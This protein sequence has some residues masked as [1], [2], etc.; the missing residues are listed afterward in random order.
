[1]SARFANRHL[2]TSHVIGDCKNEVTC[3]LCFQFG[4]K[5]KNCPDKELL[6]E[7]ERYGDYIHE[8]REGRNSAIDEQHV[9]TI[10]DPNRQLDTDKKPD[11]PIE[12]SKDIKNNEAI[13]GCRLK[14]PNRCHT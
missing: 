12:E 7:R 9:E 13:G 2:S 10:V 1:M 3:N 8:I 11:V 4:H 14:V 5:K 6:T